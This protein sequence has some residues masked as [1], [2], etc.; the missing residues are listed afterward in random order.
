MLRVPALAGTA[1]IGAIAVASAILPAPHALLT[2]VA[3]ALVF[4]V[5]GFALTTALLPTIS[6]VDERLLASIGLSLVVATCAAVLIAATR[7][8]LTRESF[9]VGLGLFSITVSAFGAVVERARMSSSSVQ[10]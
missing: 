10:S 7:I 5:P 3:L 9:D 4:F 6:A 2:M 1:L 8:G